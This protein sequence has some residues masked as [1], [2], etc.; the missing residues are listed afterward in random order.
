MPKL[1]GLEEKYWGDYKIDKEND[2][3]IYSDEKH[4]Y[5]DK[6]DNRPFISVTTLIGKYS[7]EFDEEF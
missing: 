4:V 3:T 5:I 1:E 6:N 7:Q 2:D